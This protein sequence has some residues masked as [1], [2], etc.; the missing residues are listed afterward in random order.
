M[1]SL[2]E[3]IRE[4][5][6]TLEKYGYIFIC[7][8]RSSAYVYDSNENLVD[9]AVGDIAGDTPEQMEKDL[10]SVIDQWYKI[11]TRSKR[12]GNR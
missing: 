2:D 4:S 1:S 5:N 9:I 7:T 6:I 3:K 11:H 12:K 10:E 8:D